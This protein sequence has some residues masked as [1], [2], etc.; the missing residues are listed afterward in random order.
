MNRKSTDGDSM[1]GSMVESV[2]KMSIVDHFSQSFEYRTSL[3]RNMNQKRVR[4]AAEIRE[5]VREQSESG[6]DSSLNDRCSST[7]E[8]G[9][10]NEI[11]VKYLAITASQ[12]RSETKPREEFK[13]SVGAMKDNFA[14]DDRGHRNSKARLQP[15][16]SFI[17]PEDGVDLADHPFRKNGDV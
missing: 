8:D 15:I 16:K 9:P 3:V 12:S 10:N 7:V 4:G 5:E 17:Q 2:G 13:D 1:F 11:V 14:F 6:G